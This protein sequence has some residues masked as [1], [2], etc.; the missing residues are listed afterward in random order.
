MTNCLNNGT[1]KGS[2]S[3]GVGA[4]FEQAV[5]GAIGSCYA[6]E[7]SLYERAFYSTH[8]SINVMQKAENTIITSTDLQMTTES[9]LIG[10]FPILKG[11]SESAWTISAETGTPILKA[12]ARMDALQ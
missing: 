6:I 9:D 11:E 7:S 1:I 10:L 12:F 5:G 2:G 4:N 3:W 8:E